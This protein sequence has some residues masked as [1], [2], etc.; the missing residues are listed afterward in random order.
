MLRKIIKYTLRVLLVL[1]VILILIPVL[2]YLP[3][4]QDFAR[5]KASAYA[6][7]ALGMELT[8]GRLRLAFPLRLTIDETLL[9][10]KSDTLVDC[11]R[12]SAE[13]ALWPLVRQEVEV[14]NL[15]LERLKAHYKDSLSGLDLRVRA[16]KFKLEQARANLTTSQ[17]EIESISLKTAAVRLQ[18]TDMPPK[19]ETDTAS[20]PLAWRIAIRK[21]TIDSTSFGMVTAPTVTDLA[22]Q[23]L[24]GQ[25][26]ECQVGL[27]EQ[28]VNVKSVLL[29]QGN[30]AYRTVPY[31]AADATA[32]AES[33]AD[34]SVSEPWTVHVA[35]VKLLDNSA[36]YGELNR[37]PRTGF[38]MQN[39]VLSGLNLAVDSIYNRGADVALMIRQ[40]SFVER[41]G[42]AVRR[43]EGGFSMENGGLELSHFVLQTNNSELNADISAGA[44]IMELN[45]QASSLRAKLRADFGTQDL[46]LIAPDAVP[47]VLDNRL[48]RLN[49]TTDGNLAQLNKIGLDISSPEHLNFTAD[50]Q[51]KWLLEP[52]RTDANV[53]FE[54]NFNDLAFLMQLLPDSALRSRV[55]IPE[56]MALRGTAGVRQGR[57]TV[58]TTLATGDGAIGIDGSVDL[59]KEDYD[60]RLQSDSFP[61]GQFLPHDSLGRLDL[62]LVAQGVGFD[63]LAPATHSNLKLNIDRAEYRGHDFGGAE[64][65]ARLADQQL[66]GHITDKDHALQIALD[67]EGSLTPKHQEVNLQGRVAGFD[68]AEIG[69]VPDQ[70]GGAFLLDARASATDA[71]SYSAEVSLDSIEIRN[72]YG[73]DHIRPT[74][75]AFNTNTTSTRARVTSGDLSL[76][77]AA[78]ESLDSMS[79]AVTRTMEALQ[80]QIESHSIDADSLKP[81]LPDFRLRITAGRENILNNFLSTKNISFKALRVDGFNNDSLPTAVRMQVDG[82]SYKN[83][84]LDTL[85]AAVK[86]RNDSLEYVLR[87]ANRPGNLDNVAEAG[88]YGHLVQNSGQINVLQRN[89]AKATGFRFGF[90]VI[91]N[92]SSVS[93][94]MTSLDPIFG[95]EPWRANEGNYVEYGFDNRVDADLALT[96]DSQ[97]LAVKTLP[98]GNSSSSILFDFAGLNIGS[99]MSVLPSAP[100]ID[101]VL[102]TDMRLNMAPDSISVR[103]DVTIADLSYGKQRFG[104]VDLGLIYRHDDGHMAD[105][106][107]K[108]D[109]AKILTVQG[110]YEEDRES[111]LDFMVNITQFPLQRVNVFL[112]ADLASLTGALFTKLH[113]G[114]RPET[115][116]LNGGI[117]FSQTNV[118]VPMIGTSFGLSAD[119]IRID[120]NRV[121]F[122]KYAI[123]SPNKSPLTINGYVNLENFSNI[124][125]DLSLKASDFQFVNVSRKENTAVYG[126]AYLDLDA[127]AKGPLDKLVVRGSAGL[128][129]GTDISYVMQDS[130]MELNEQSQDVVKFVSFDELDMLEPTE[131]PPAVKIGG[132]DLL[133]NI[134]INRDVKA[135]VDLSADRSNRIDLQ[136]GGNLTFAINPLGDMSLSGKYILWG[137]TVKYNPPIISQQLFKITPDSYVDWTGNVADPAFNITAVKTARATVSTD[138]QNSRSMN[139]DI[140]I[141]IRN[142]LNDLVVTFGLSAPEDLT[143]QNQ[144]NS[145]TAEQRATQAMNL[146]IYNTYTGPGTTAKVTA[147]NPLNTFIQKELNQWAQNNLKG[148]DL[149]FGINSYEGDDL[150][151]QRTDYSYQLSK[152]L[153][154]NRMRVVIG[155]KVS[156]DN[157]P[158]H[159]VS[160]NLIDD[161]SL[162]YMLTKRD[163]MYIRVFRHTGYESILEGQITETGVGF[164][165]RK[166]ILRLGDLFRSTNPKKQKKNEV[167]ASDK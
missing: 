16:D 162:E 123:S 119:T 59:K 14:R 89:R 53:R 28:Q 23:L 6:S 112:P 103:G 101:G 163:N 129:R 50:G 8:I 98:T 92:D 52:L 108:I 86:Q 51:A 40:M 167:E 93:A 73:T 18:L 159:N 22:V 65:V 120:A 45:P 72:E 97:R 131:A 90:D 1:L 19:M 144:L 5:A 100:P 115:P 12:L 121:K 34:K 64:I 68:L 99:V 78:N 21:I 37:L 154:S 46:K 33:V 56:S 132:I 111:P 91:W 164:V 128:L 127:T 69:V 63:P 38:D 134:D 149:S 42:L 96:H 43:A 55:A 126:K 165:I 41:S 113:I 70:I 137:G 58:A 4:I 74:S 35:S 47:K 2:L 130:P 94:S 77:F 31:E 75:V 105:A 142:T 66:S 60:L 30:Y 124:V 139:F 32:N 36:E 61:L 44:G 148:V 67:F 102:G 125:A 122:N 15:E 109:D 27:G 29:D 116:R 87:Y 136:G 138:G 20:L 25:V 161:I 39:I 151:S 107:V 152:N 166:K 83:F 110:D 82:L 3:P 118:R 150:N 11:R 104:T 158:A 156:T 62:N 7:H 76:A 106:I 10:D 80:K 145:L 81:V 157:D 133:M 160:D 13:V 155:G 146:L 54:G 141:N 26:E 114:G 24:H 153:F 147:G 85:I 88:V 84:T 17:A 135:A 117:Q 9:I 95:Y 49:F 48:V 79:T 143:M 57:Y 140:S 71:G